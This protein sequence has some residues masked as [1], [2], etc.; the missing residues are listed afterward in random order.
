MPGSA[1]SFGQVRKLRFSADG[2]FSYVGSGDS[3]LRKLRVPD[4]TVVWKVFAGGW[5][6]VNGL[7][8][9]PDGAWLVAGT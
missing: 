8:L 3:N 9:T 4:G 2:Q 7:D 5:P 6:F 1:P